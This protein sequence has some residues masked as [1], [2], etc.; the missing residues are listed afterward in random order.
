MNALLDSIHACKSLISPARKAGTNASTIY[1]PILVENSQFFN[2]HTGW[3]KGSSILKVKPTSNYEAM[4]RTFIMHSHIHP[5][6]QSYM[7][8]KTLTDG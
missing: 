8:K 2:I 1:V 3:D 4:L 7:A 6:L 5:V